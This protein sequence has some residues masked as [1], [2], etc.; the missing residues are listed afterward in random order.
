MVSK[1]KKKKG[2]KP[3]IS[4]RFYPTKKPVTV[5]MMMK[6]GKSEILALII[7][8]TE[9]MMSTLF[10]NR[11]KKYWDNQCIRIGENTIQY[12]IIKSKH[13]F[14][15]STNFKLQKISKNFVVL[16]QKWKKNINV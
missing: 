8:N 6:I 5:V 1:K 2:K 10:A 11:I 15:G 14:L 3:N 7:Q 12:I 9:N 13:G 4:N 16:G